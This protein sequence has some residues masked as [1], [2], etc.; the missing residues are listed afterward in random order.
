M[1]DSPNLN[2]PYIMAA[3][4]QK[5]ITHNEAIKTIDVI[6]QLS[7]LNKNLTAEPSTPNEGERHIVAPLA[8]GSWANK[9]NQIAA[10]QDGAWV[11][12]PAQI[13]WLAWV[14]DL[15]QLYAWDGASWN[16]ISANIN[17][18]SLVGV[19]T[20]ADTTNRLAVSS[21]NTL[22]NHEG[23]SHRIKINKNASTDTASFLFQSNW[24]GRAEIGLTGDDDFH[25]KVSADGSAWSDSFTI[26]ASTGEANF[27]QP[28][29]LKQYSKIS[30]PSSVSSA[31]L[32]YVHDATGGSCLAYCDGTSW[33]RVSDNSV[34]N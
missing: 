4:A 3:Q 30:L 1:S 32:I 24:S 11:F 5:H 26:S 16:G 33:K 23:S 25:F 21:P 15:S 29:A 8:T 22:F 17:P 27:A 2:L 9:D 28:V 18:A 14:T 7:V 13:G 19:N 10:Y 34:I 20:T 6:V 31:R 12:H